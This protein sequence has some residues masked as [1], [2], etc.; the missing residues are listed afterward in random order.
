MSNFD[1][2]AEQRAQLLNNLTASIGEVEVVPFSELCLADKRAGEIM[3]MAG[4]TAIDE[5]F[6]PIP[7]ENNGRLDSLPVGKE[8]VCY[9]VFPEG[10]V[11]KIAITR[12]ADGMGKTIISYP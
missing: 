12:M 9:W 11:F 5:K 8:S 4:I 1:E 7:G 2:F 6:R 10:K 3:F